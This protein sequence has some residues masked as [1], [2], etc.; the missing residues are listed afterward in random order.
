LGPSGCGKT[1][2][3]RIL[4]GF[5]DPSSGTVRLDGK[6]I[7]GLPPNQRNTNTVFQNYAL[8]PHLTAFENIAFPLR[9]KKVS[10][11]EI[12]KRV[13]E[14]LDLVQLRGQE[15]KKPNQMS[16]GQKQRVS[17]ARALI[18]EPKV[19]LL[20]EPLSAL[21]AKLR[22]QLL[23]DLDLIHDQVG[24][25]FVYVTHDQG[26]ALSVSDRVA[27]MSQGRILQIG[28]PIE[29]YESPADS[30]VADFIGENNFLEGTITA[31]AD[32]MVT[33]DTEGMGPIQV[34]SEPSRQFAVGDR[35]RH[36]IRPEKIRIQT[37]EPVNTPENN[38][39][40]GKVFE[41]I[42]TGFQ[43]KFFVNIESGYRFKVMKQHVQYLEVGQDI[44]WDTNVYIWWNPD[45]GYIVEK[46]K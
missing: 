14:Y 18:N 31:V 15:N 34:T 41:V 39:L 43:S 22:Q 23:I 44:K 4:A 11:K 27:V 5:E 28:S 30:F 35:V 17:I 45:D 8:F 26:E 20:D 16:G 21:D 46:L 1:T 25:T 9:L 42:Y 36:S 12:K 29:I 24:I 3:L 13:F 40:K 6:D 38:V 37:A 19:L 2:L 32:R 10:N 33:I 7:L